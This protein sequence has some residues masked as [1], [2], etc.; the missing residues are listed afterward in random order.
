MNT[1][2]FSCLSVR[3]LTFILCSLGVFGSE[4]SQAQVNTSCNQAIPAFC[5]DIITGTTIAT[6]YDGVNICGS[7]G[8]SGQRWFS[9]VAPADGS[10][11]INLQNGTSYDSQLHV[12]TGDCSNLTCHAQNDDFFGLQ[13]YLEYPV[14]NGVT[15]FVR[16]GGYQSA[17]GH[18]TAEFNM[19][20]CSDPLACNYNPLT[21]N[22][23]NLELNYSCYY[24][25]LYYI[26]NDSDGY[27]QDGTEQEYCSNP[28]PGYA[29]V[30]GD[31]NDNDP[32][33]FPGATEIC[34]DGIDQDCDGQIDESDGGTVLAF[35]GQNDYITVCNPVGNCNFYSKEAWIYIES[36]STNQHLISSMDSPFWLNNLRLTGGGS[37]N[38]YNQ[39][40]PNQ[41]P[42]NTWVHVALTYSY[43]ASIMTLYVNGNVVASGY[44]NL[45]Y[46]YTVALG[47]LPNGSGFFGGRMDEVR[48]WNEART[49]A[50]IQ[51]YMNQSLTGN[52]PN[53][54]RYY[55]FE[56]DL[57]IPGGN[58]TGIST[59]DDLSN[60]CNGTMYNFDLNGGGSN[61]MAYNDF[62]GD[63]YEEC[64]DCDDT[65]PS[66]TMSEWY[67][68]LDGDGFGDPSTLIIQ[69]D[70][71]GADY[72]LT[73]GDCN[74]SDP[75][76]NPGVDEIC[77][78]LIDDNCNGVVD[79]SG[80]AMAFDG[81]N[82]YVDTNFGVSG[83]SFT[84]EFRV[85]RT[86]EN[87]TQYLSFASDSKIIINGSG[88]LQYQDNNGYGPV[89]S[90]AI[91]LNEW[92][93][94][95][96][97]FDN[98]ISLI[99]LY[100]NGI[101]VGS[102]NAYY[103]YGNGA[104][105]G[106]ASSSFLGR[107]DEVRFWNYAR[108]QSE[109]Q[110]SMNSILTG[111]ESGLLRYYNFEDA[112]I[113]AGGDNTAYSST[114][115]VSG[116]VNGVLSNFN[117][118]GALSNWVPYYD[119]DLDGF[120]ICTDCDDSNPNI[121]IISW[122][123]DTDG[124][125]YGDPSSSIISC[126]QP[127]PSYTQNNSDCNDND[128]AI[129]PGT[130]EICDN[131]IDENCDGN[132]DNIGIAL[133]ID[134]NN[135]YLNTNYYSSYSSFTKEAWIYT[136]SSNYTQYIFFSNDSRVYLNGGYLYHYDACGYQTSST[137][138]VP[139]N[140][141]VHIAVTYTY[142]PQ[143]L[144]LYVNGIENGAGYS[145]C[146]Y[147]GT[148][149]IGYS[150]SSY[151]G[152]MDEIRIWNTA[153]SASQIQANMS[154]SLV[155]TEPNLVRLYNFENTSV[156][157]GGDNA[158]YTSADDL[159]NNYD[160]QLINFALSGTA[161]NWIN[162]FDA[163]GDGYGTCEDCD[164]NNPSV[165]IFTWYP[166]SDGDGYGDG[167]NPVVSCIQPGP[168]FTQVTGDCDDA[169]ANVNPG[170]PED[171]TNGIDDNCNGT[172]DDQG[173]AMAFDGSNDRIY[174][175]YPPI[176]YTSYTKEAWIYV[177]SNNSNQQIISGSESPF[178]LSNRYL[179]AG[180]QYNYTNQQS[181]VQVPLNTWTHVAVTYNYGTAQMTLFMDGNIVAQGSGNYSYGNETG[182]GSYPNGGE[183]FG[184][185][186]DE[187][188]IWNYARTPLEI[189][190]GMFAGLS[191][192]ESGLVRYYNFENPSVVPGGNNAPYST[193]DDLS[194]S[195][196]DAPLYNFSLNG[197]QSNWIPRYDNDGD[198][199]NSCEDCNDNDAGIGIITWYPDVDGDGF[200]DSS[201]PIV[202]C[203]PPGPEYT[204]IDGDCD[205]S[206]SAINPDAI[207]ICDNLIDDNCNGEIDDSGLAMHFDG[208]N[209]YLYTGY[210]MPG[211]TSFTKEAWIFRT[212]GNYY[213]TILRNYYNVFWV[214]NG[215]LTAGDYNNW[216]IVQAPSQIPMNSWTHVAVTYEYGTGALKIYQNGILVA[217]SSSSYSTSSSGNQ[218]IGSYDGGNYFF[219]GKM[220]NVR[221]WN[222]ALN[223]SQI[224]SSMN[225]ALNG[226][227]PGMVLWYNFENPSVTP[228]GSNGSYNTVEDVSA[229]AYT[230]TLGNFALSGVTSNWMPHYDQDGDGLDLCDDCDDNNAAITTYTW[231]PD[232]DGDGFG[233]DGL[234]IVQC[235]QPDN[236]YTQVGGDCND[237]DAGVNPDATEICENGIDENCNGIIDDQ[238]L[239]MNFDGNDDYLYT[240]YYS[241]YQSFTK[242]AW[243]Y[244][245]S[246]NSTQYIF[247]ANDSR[248]YIQNGY[249]YHYD[250]CGYQVSSGIQVPLNAWTHVAV[251]YTYGPQNIKLYI[252]GL[253]VGSGYSYCPYGGYTQ[254]GY[255]G[256]SFGGRMDEVRIWN[257]PLTS[258]QIIA[259]MNGGLLGNEPNLV[260]YYNFED[261]NA[262]PSGDNTG[263]SITQD[264]TNNGSATL[265]NFT[266]NGT[267]SNWVPY[268]D[269]DGD[270]YD[271]CDDCDDNN[272][273]VTIYTWYPDNDGDGFGD[274]NSPVVSCTQ[275]NPTDVLTNGDCNDSD[276]AI[277]P[278]AEELCN[279][280]DDDCDGYIDNLGIALA[281][282]GNN[283]HF[284]TGYSTSY[285]PFT[286]EARIL[287]QSGNSTQYI[288]FSNDSKLY[289]QNG[290]L[291]YQ[292]YCGYTIGSSTTVPLNEWSHVAVTFS[293]YYVTLYINGNVVGGGNAYCPYGYGTYVGYS[294]N[295]FGGRI[296]DVS[297]WN[298]SKS[299]SQI[300]TDMVTSFSGTESGLMRL[301]TFENY[302]VTPG[303][304]NSSFTSVDDLSASNYDAGLSN[305][306]LNGNTSNWVSQADFDGDGFDQCV[307]CDDN[308]ASITI[309]EWYID[310]D[311]DGYG[312]GAP[313]VQCQEPGPE[314]V[315]VDGDCDDS[316][317]AIN[318]SAIEICDNNI[319]DNC[320]GSVD[321]D[322][323]ALH[324]DGSNDYVFTGYYLNSTSSFTKEAWIYPT[325]GN[326][327]QHLF[328]SVYN[329]LW[330]YNGYLYAGDN[331]NQWLISTPS[332]IPTN[333]WTHVACTYDYGASLLKI[334]VNGVLQG[335][336]TSNYSTS[337]SAYQY[338]GS[339]EGGSDFFGGRMDNVRLWSFAK[340]D[341]Q[342]LASFNAQIDGSESGIA[343]WYNF[344]N[345]SAIP[346]GNN[347]GISTVEDVSVN[348]FSG[349][350]Y[351]FG[352][353]GT[354]G[355]WV[356]QFDGD[357][358]GLNTCED[359]DDNNPSI[360]IFT[361]YPDTDGDGFGDTGNPIVQCEQPGPDYTLIGGDCN[362]SDAGTNPSAEEICDNGIDENCNG[363][364]DDQGI[365]MSFDGSNDYIYT[366]RYWS[367][368]SFTKEAKIFMTS[369]NSTQYLFYAYG[370]RFYVQNG[371]L[372][373]YD[374][375]GYQTTSSVPVPLNQWA[376]VAVTYSYGANTI[377]LY[378][379]GVEVGSG[380]SGCPYGDY[381]YIGYA[382]SSF[383]GR[384]DEVR[385]WN[386]ARTQSQIQAQINS[387]L[388]GSESGLVLLYNFE[389]PSVTPAGSNNAFNIVDDLTNN[390]DGTLT[391]FTLNGPS[392][393]WVS[394]FDLD[395]DGLDFCED[396]DDTNPNIT[397]YVWY[398]DSDTDG[399]GNV[400]TAT[401]QCDPP[402]SNWILDAGDCND[403]NPNIN[404]GEPEICD[405]G[406]DDNCN[407]IIDDSGIA[408]AF[409]GSNDR[410]YSSYP[411]I[412]YTSYTKEAWIFT[413]SNNTYQQIISST[414]APFW[415]V[416]R[417]LTA[418]GQGNAYNIQAPTQIPL[419]TWT[420]VAVTYNYSNS[421]MTLYVNGVQVAQNSGNYSYGYEVGVGSYPGGGDYFGGRIDDVRI[422]NYTRSANDIVNSMNTS[423]NGTTIGLVRYYNFENPSVTPS[424]NNAGF[425]TADDLSSSNFDAPLY[426]F[427]MSGNSSNWV[428]RY[429]SDLDGVNVC[430]D[431][432]DNNPNIT[433]I[434]WYQDSDGDGFGDSGTAITECDSP[435]IDYVTL[436]GDCD[437]SAFN[438]NP[439]VIEIC[440][441]NI[442]DN[443]N[444]VIDD[445]GL[446]LLFDGSNDYVNTNYSTNQYQSYTKE[447]WV[448]VN[449]NNAQH[450]ISGNV[451]QLWINGGYLT[452]GDYNSW[453]MMQ[454]PNP[455][456][457][458]TWVHVAMTFDQSTQ[459]MKLYKNGELVG[460][461]STPYGSYYSSTQYLGSW[462]GSSYFFSGKMDN[463]R[464]WSLALNQSQIQS[465]MNALL[466]G[467]EPG[468]ALWYNFEAPG[469]VPAGNNT[470]VTTVEDVSLN[471]FNGNLYNFSLQGT[472]SNWMP[473]WDADNDGFDICTDCDDTNSAITNITWYADT[474]GD[475]FGDENTAQLNCTPPGPEWTTSSGDCDDTSNTVYPGATE[476]CDNNIDDDCDGYVDAGNLSLA[477]D[478]NDDYVYTDYSTSYQPFTKEAWVFSTNN[479]GTH[480][481]F[482]S[483]DSRLYVQNNY[484]YYQD[485]CGYTISTGTPMPLNQW[486]HVAVTFS[487]YN[488]QIYINGTLVGSGNAYCP[489]G[490]PTCIGYGSS[491]W[492]GR[493]DEVKFWNFVKT[494]SQ[495]Q[496]GMNDVLS[497]NESGLMR[498]YNFED[499][500]IIA[501]GNNTAYSVTNDLSNHYDGTLN[502]M[503]R[504]GASSNWVSYFDMDGDGFDF[505]EDCD[506]NNASITIYTW[507]QDSDGDGFGDDN[508]ATVQC[509]SPGPEWILIDGDCDD[510]DGN[511]SPSVDEICNG[512]DDDCNGIVDDT[513]TALAFDGSNDYV[514]TGYTSAYQS[515]TR[516]AWIK[517]NDI[518]STQ[519]IFFSSD[520]KLYLQNGFLYYQ[521]YCGYTTSSSQQIAA[522]T[523]THVAVVYNYPSSQIT[524]YVNGAVVGTGNAYCPYGYVLCVGYGSNSFNGRIDD[525]RFWNFAKTQTEIQN[526]LNIALSG[527]ETGLVVYYTFENQAVN[528]GEDNEGFAIAEDF[529]PN[530]YNGSLNNFLLNGQNSNWVW[531]QDGDNDGANVCEDCD[532]N[533]P[534]IGIIT[535]YFDG[536]G[537]G[538]GDD[539]SAIVDCTS[540]GSGWTETGG[541]C[542]DDDASVNPTSIEICNNGIDDNCNGQVDEGGLAM[543]FDG[544][545]DY[546]AS[547]FIINANQSFTKEAWILPNSYG[548]Q[549]L[550]WGNANP[551]WLNNGYV[552]AG[553]Y[554]NYNIVQSPAQVPLNQW[555]HVAVT[556]NYSTS[557]IKLF[558]NGVEVAQGSSYYSSYY[559][560]QQF[561]ASSSGSSGFFN[562]K[563]DE[564]R[565][566]NVVRTASEIAN[567]MYLDLGGNELGL[568]L[569]YNFK[570]LGA[571]ANGS[572][573]GLNSVE[574]YSSN[575]YTGTLYNLTLDGNTSNWVWRY[576]DDG[577]GYDICTDCDDT[578]A[579]VNP[580]MVELLC[581][582]ID[583]NCDGQI[584]EGSLDGCTDP[585]AC[586]YNA[587]AT[588]EDGTCTYP[589]LWYADADGDGLGDPNSTLMNCGQPEGFVT[590]NTD[591]DDTSGTVNPG[592]P[593]DPCNGI[594]DNCNGII[595]EG[596]IFG[597]TDPIA[598][599]YDPAATCD[600]GSC[601]SPS[602]WYDDD[603]GD[604]FGDPE[605]AVLSLGQPTG[606]VLNNT[607][608]DDQNPLLYPG[609][610]EISCNALDDDCDGL[611]D[612]DGVF[613]GCIDPVACNFD[614]AANCDDGTCYYETI[615]FLDN[616]GD[617][618]GVLSVVAFGCEPPLGYADIPGDCDDNDP[619][620]NPIISEI[621]CNDLDDN[622]N[623]EI[624]EN[625]LLG[626]TDPA[627]VNF[628]EYATCDDF[629]C[630][631]TGC[632]YLGAVNFNPAASVDDGSCLF[633]G[634]TDPGA[635]NFNPA[636]NIENGTCIY[637]GTLGCTYP[638]AINYNP[639][640]SDDDGSCT[641]DLAWPCQADLNFDGFVA[642]QDLL[643]FISVFGS[644]CTE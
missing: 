179:T 273:S 174:T 159:T 612:E 622:C 572:N 327:Y 204:E 579:Q 525:V 278:S 209:D 49:Q 505:C 83:T 292:D 488:V 66:V 433:T 259:N 568:M 130:I 343:F 24:S 460:S 68:D 183:Y 404:P 534:E 72:I 276:A 344:E 331:N 556:Y 92:A 192:S 244:R 445:D 611:I 129:S 214:V 320:D 152:R 501:G 523:W 128:P 296:D 219:G 557:T 147:G 362:D 527:N 514:Y 36:S 356:P 125:G 58:N 105:L 421:Q 79:D 7:E 272:P 145:Y 494:Q 184:G 616:D 246:S 286:K 11:V 314:Y 355:N 503:T 536:D 444:G 210:N 636:A 304:S 419:N 339:Y 547:Q 119:Y 225:S 607:D 307:D 424:G 121:T 586:N 17:A 580:G 521:D 232:V 120:D 473:Q 390:F 242:E 613:G 392:S 186:M 378:L 524:L 482:F 366:N 229:N 381:D 559:S 77:D 633:E 37:Y 29:Q 42:L 236:T 610:I 463:V 218:Y 180:G 245:T 477:F 230:G 104:Y 397:I 139:M 165:G 532:D 133:S 570:N 475:G 478:G 539:G 312:D 604:G 158:A 193:V 107:M 86:T 248:L 53:L 12:Y 522:N 447:A 15:Y 518:N 418:G 569:Y 187:V 34:L 498:Y 606:F 587:D 295:S 452:A 583:D 56:T 641:F 26:D 80:T 262:L 98:S 472:S 574:D 520:S 357:N 123:A 23:C 136:T 22:E 44:G 178:W 59:I 324:F 338:L 126:T 352:L 116:N 571:T 459:M 33:L 321:N 627:A 316:D 631:I 405:N 468:L 137:T 411:P 486:T 25:V 609:A 302:A 253:D 614:P 84:K 373:Y 18:F 382:S 639:L 241:G 163:D 333:T 332:Q 54:L 52:E 434:T 465:N 280:I 566:W 544:S 439:G 101:L 581:N 537:D 142:G 408:M 602:L 115:D 441:N 592:T 506:D 265:Y 110:S 448:F 519:Y 114:I 412:G 401:V 82:D 182:V 283:D 132:I 168:D 157:P 483:N 414:E 578:N 14:V 96:V 515:F 628:N 143:N 207:E 294:S 630:L 354:T 227:E 38:Y 88:Y 40:D 582:D 409:D 65:D 161:S 109:I 45:S 438:I 140:Q 195:N 513:G 215:Y 212:S 365:A 69:C 330:M 407:G 410:L 543:H 638:D 266:R 256:S 138:P 428:Y 484:L 471:S 305:F 436:G 252:N 396:C 221:I 427:Q 402:G 621:P 274:S 134:G 391:N 531:L 489:Y 403:N 299:Q 111:T 516:E 336:V 181:A 526:N 169:S 528:P 608:C 50:Q 361:W 383:G 199:I 562:G 585:L 103:H 529:S 2:T 398:L 5:G 310:N 81:S 429:D 374:P 430:E 287:P 496:Q 605:D 190:S 369:S 400:A 124:D 205:D 247:F 341:A 250:A 643:I 508:T 55:N 350:L 261:V 222:F 364:I 21:G 322:G 226:N 269:A 420:H 162:F 635:A 474:D 201:Q 308:N 375:C 497:G 517:T 297:F 499:S 167:N 535:W 351:N 239:A 363:N 601:N 360:T 313:V 387:S 175:A 122:Y 289:I 85:F 60:Y 243:I 588:C 4:F 567:S 417:Y 487:V 311:G 389:N 376:H 203:T 117:K 600:D 334:Y 164:D 315:L 512:I 293:V 367:Y 8:T 20:S 258:A 458:N 57:V 626:C 318:P 301:Y 406:I 575:S 1:S 485:Y 317:S 423:F 393:N 546:L 194:P 300:Q 469:A 61:W 202:E 238:S 135:D 198:G 118:T 211:G 6:G 457:L 270:G 281:F 415:L 3:I 552:V 329:R 615:W 234:P 263:L 176:G 335:S 453:Y 291:Y 399:Y 549:Y 379:N 188:R 255:S 288:F 89:S 216:Y 48:I 73:G 449:S 108:S 71:P 9:F 264:L 62:D 220:D 642:I 455:F 144:R 462:Q 74:D 224:S 177:T 634:C 632:M 228:A 380:Y 100:I 268:F 347:A 112:G 237:A 348:N 577:D 624:D 64:S 450:I 206:N 443:C 425:N 548:T 426:N 563:M 189:S 99:K 257:V 619:M 598:C 326:T 271:F 306:T 509:I 309:F 172:I 282:D 644:E 171:C 353:N 550:I 479:N 213:E 422:W 51:Q 564:I 251:S 504:N 432:D 470:S 554:F 155:G 595:D 345:L 43:P 590:D 146:P 456:V 149:S 623:G 275:P 28:G 599:N 325:S 249:L 370:S 416:N 394:Y 507:Y 30:G 90:Q 151:G 303:G 94:V 260:R 603:D 39:Q 279:E 196:Y 153:L 545:N 435:G 511:I 31:C 454:D 625:G 481:L 502:N 597:C 156:I 620:V 67:Q 91:P 573:T 13:S 150:S 208:S 277:N 377:K 560:A 561:I 359:C 233:D 490:Y 106:Y 32:T 533:N 617:G 538:F 413:T 328:S 102:G 93:H 480:Y 223:D 461:A 530:S 466:T 384:M 565:I 555:T 371:Y 170:M 131:G 584:D 386:I 148:A 166:D 591:C 558:V 298:Y 319:D 629:S 200:G 589:T 495:I 340:S 267:T 596:Q 510:S 191:G 97:T 451:N 70:P 431:C 593:E 358:D 87:G 492:Q 542:S 637:A 78:N 76:V 141:W 395:G 346:A 27:G 19:V 47:A 464:I 35:D 372:Y 640:A 254:I 63:G 290:Y 173:I 217:S 154:L 500:G 493:V 323:I 10:A 75:S 337:G 285:Q 342:M 541:D 349:T 491:S 46:G 113:N 284:Y 160:G 446:A 235:E 197:A 467:S 41:L 16:I 368:S 185:R 618:V 437:D 551:L 553:D 231:Y 594:D 240:N 127:D 442:D 440:D 385:I 476:I 576:D 540:P 95:A 388:T